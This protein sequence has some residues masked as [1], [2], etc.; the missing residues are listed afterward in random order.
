[1][2]IQDA[3]NKGLDDAENAVIEKLNNTLNRVDDGPFANPELEAVRQRLLVGIPDKNI[4]NI[5]EDM[6][7][8]RDFEYDSHGTDNIIISF[9]AELMKYL[10]GTIGGR[11]KFSVKIKDSVNRVKYNLTFE[12]NRVNSL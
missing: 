11:N 1:M 2:T 9:Y 3:Y 7:N 8:G 10:L 5:F 4:L 12:K 6:I